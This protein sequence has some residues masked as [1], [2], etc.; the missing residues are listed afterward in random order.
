MSY[1][2]ELSDVNQLIQFAVQSHPL[3]GSALAEQQATA[4]EVQAAKYNVFP[5]PSIQ[6]GYDATNGMTSAL[7]VRQPLWTGGKL[8]ADINQ[9]FYTDQA[10]MAN[11][12]EQRNTVAKNTVNAWQSYIEAASLQYLYTQTIQDLIQ[13]EQMM[14]RRVGQG[15]SARIELDLVNN[16]MLQMQNQYDAA[17]EQ[18]R[19]AEARLEQII[20]KKLGNVDALNQQNL[21]MMLAQVKQNSQ[22]F[23]SL[24]F[25][26]QSQNHPAVVKAKYQTEAA[27]AQVA[28]RASQR[29]PTVYTQY[30]YDYFHDS[31]KDNSQLSVGLAFEPG[32]SF[33]NF[34]ITRASQ[35]RVSSLEQSSEATRRSINEEMQTQYQ[36]LLSSRSRAKALTS[37]VAGAKIVTDSYQRQFIA[38]RKSWLDVLNAVREH[39]DY[40]AQLVQTEA[41]LLAAYYK[42]Q[43]DFAM[44]PWQHLENNQGQIPSNPWLDIF[45]KT[46]DKLR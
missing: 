11:I 38:G 1:A 4:E 7:R 36:Q 30:Q 22:Q 45:E 20:G 35:A 9:A 16:R 19:V 12:A 33:S 18:K 46:S 14:Q 40:Q 43:I 10:A 39:S 27:K 41:A 26:E 3:V 17:I 44:M 37:A 31:N 28:S 24:V 21:Q 2:T 6:S 29:Y 5:T 23:E 15:V 13:F 42:L 32:A 34:A 25:S 8:T